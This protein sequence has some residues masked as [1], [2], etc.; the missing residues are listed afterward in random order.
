ML[1]KYTS[2]SELVP[3]CSKGF[4]SFTR[5]NA[6]LLKV[7]KLVNITN[8]S[9]MNFFTKAK[10]CDKCSQFKLGEISKCSCPKG[11]SGQESSKG[12]GVNKNAK[13]K[14]F[15]LPENI[16]MDD[17]VDYLVLGEEGEFVK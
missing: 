9:D 3:N 5:L 11:E 15:V 6:H 16:N 13:R 10:K 12:K 4:G 17:V 1:D 2:P 8:D 7:H 14:D